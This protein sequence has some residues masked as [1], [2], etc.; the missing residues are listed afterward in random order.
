MAS[1]KEYSICESKNTASNIK[2]L[3]YNQ[4][5]VEEDL[6]RVEMLNFVTRNIYFNENVARLK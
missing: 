1:A 5:N 4:L 3:Q 2:S 6:I